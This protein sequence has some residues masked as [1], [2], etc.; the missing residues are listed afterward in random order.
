MA[1]AR[2]ADCK[3]IIVLLE[4]FCE[5]YGAFIAF[6]LAHEIKWYRRPALKPAGRAF[7]KTSARMRVGLNRHSNG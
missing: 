4:E 7:R 3:A 5:A 1:E 6:F 2:R